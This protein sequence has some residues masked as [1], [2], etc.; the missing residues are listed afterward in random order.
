MHLDSCLRI[1]QNNSH[2]LSS[3][4]EMKR[5]FPGFSDFKKLYIMVI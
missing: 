1:I 5:K 3:S 4:K 2:T